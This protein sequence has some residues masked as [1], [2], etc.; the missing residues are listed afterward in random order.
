MV[1]ERA[2]H[3]PELPEAERE[4]L[5]ERSMVERVYSRLKDEFGARTD[6]WPR[7]RRVP[8]P[9]RFSWLASFPSRPTR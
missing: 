4:R 7:G 6:Q 5:V 1:Y 3:T 2:D 9:L 8:G